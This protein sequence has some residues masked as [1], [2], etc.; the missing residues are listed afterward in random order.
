MAESRVAESRVA[1]SRVADGEDMREYETC[2]DEGG[3]FLGRGAVSW[4]CESCH[5]IGRGERIRD[6]D[7]FA[8]RHLDVYPYRLC[9]H[10]NVREEDGR[11]ERITSHRLWRRRIEKTNREDG[12]GDMYTN[13]GCVTRVGCG[14]CGRFYERPALCTLSH[15]SDLS[16]ARGSFCQSPACR[17]CT[18]AG[19]A[20]PGGRA[21][22]GRAPH[23]RRGQREP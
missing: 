10:Q 20:P 16:R 21:T 22:P 8:T 11:V 1:E 9:D 12:S 15:L 3:I 13:S 4:Q 19:G 6:E 7:A 14:M 2:L 18:R 17:R 23:A 5:V